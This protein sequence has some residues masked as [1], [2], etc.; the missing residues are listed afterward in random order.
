MRSDRFNKHM[1]VAVLLLAGVCIGCGEKKNDDSKVTP[2][3]HREEYEDS[4]RFDADDGADDAELTDSQAES[5]SDESEFD[6]SPD[7]SVEND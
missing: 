3:G 2:G 6:E 5:A 1:F 4:T 7:D